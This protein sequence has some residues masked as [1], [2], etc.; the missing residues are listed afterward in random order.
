MAACT[1]EKS[2]ALEAADWIPQQFQSST[3]SLE[4]YWRVTGLQS[5]SEGQRS[6]Y[7]L[8]GVFVGHTH[9][10]HVYTLSTECSCIHS[11]GVS[12]KGLI[13]RADDEVG[14]P[15]ARQDVWC[16]AIE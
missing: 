4:N 7:V 12:Y 6:R 5:T 8:R 14:F 11:S 1:L 2:R 15:I 13:M 16:P 10:A 3:G 9:M